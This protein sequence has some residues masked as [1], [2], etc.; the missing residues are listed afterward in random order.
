MTEHQSPVDPDNTP[1]T[2]RPVENTPYDVKRAARTARFNAKQ[3]KKQ[4]K[5]EARAVKREARK[6]WR[7]R[8]NPTPWIAKKSSDFKARRQAN[9]VVITHIPAKQDWGIA[10]AAVLA[11][12]LLFGVFGY[13]VPLTE[14]YN[15]QVAASIQHDADTKAAADKAIKD[16]QAAAD[17]KVKDAQVAADKVAADA[18]ANADKLVNDAKAKA[19]AAEAKLASQPYG[20]PAPAVATSSTL[21]PQ[22]ETYSKLATQKGQTEGVDY[23]FN[24]DRALA[25]AVNPGVDTFGSPVFSEQE[26]VARLADG[27]VNSNKAIATLQER[28][29]LK[30]GF[31]ISRD[32]ILNAQNF[33]CVQMLKANQSGDMASVTADGTVHWA[34]NFVDPA[35]SVSCAY[36]GHEV[37][38][39]IAMGKTV[40]SIGFRGNCI[41]VQELPAVVENQ[42]PSPSQPPV[43]IIVHQTPPPTTTIV[44]KNVQRCDVTIKMVVTI[45][46]EQA[47]DTNRYKDVHSP[48]CQPVTKNVQRC[49]VTIKMVVTISEEQ[50]KDTNRYKDVHSP[51]C[52][53]VVVCLP[54][55]IPNPDT[56]SAVKCLDKKDPAVSPPL[57]SDHDPAVVTTPAAPIVANPQ[58]IDP[59][60][61]VTAPAPPTVKAPGS[62]PIPNPAPVPVVETPAPVA[63]HPGTP[64]GDPD[65]VTVASATVV[66]AAAV[67]HVAAATPVK[68]VATATTP[69]QSTTTASAAHVATAPVGHATVAPAANNG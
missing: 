5:H 8:M 38:E 56:S 20:P 31:T 25:A 50:A 12:A 47:K 45:S 40:V 43:I 4:V 36:V 53:P 14:K 68:A 18:K 22:Q 46:E 13:A 58:P 21:T 2:E 9:R 67:T 62:N 37:V 61:P 27:S 39:K 24:I 34:G 42:P 59:A 23:R 33:Q 30:N 51:E 63:T 69:V 41:N 28:E 35:Y 15:Q 17:Q 55:Q 64:I 65:Q 26:L 57:P 7:T 54:S 6:A 19:N 44:F 48:E 52:Q 49:D 11:V 3:D 1:H 16:A 10:I 32:E 66:K 60:T 29:L